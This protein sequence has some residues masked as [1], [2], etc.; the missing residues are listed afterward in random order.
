MV[1]YL[2]YVYKIA[3]ISHVIEDRSNSDFTHVFD[4][5]SYSCAS[6]LELM[7]GYAN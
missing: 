6:L 4:V 2:F 7:N 3:L 1:S 5:L